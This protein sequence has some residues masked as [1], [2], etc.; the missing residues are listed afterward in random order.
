MKQEKEETVANSE[1]RAEERRMRT[2][3]LE[4]VFMLTK[5]AN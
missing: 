5:D 4:M 1:P 2:D 3:S